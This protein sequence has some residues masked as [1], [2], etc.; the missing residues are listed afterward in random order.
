MKIAGEYV[1]AG[2]F[3]DFF[4]GLTSV[5]GTRRRCDLGDKGRSTRRR[6]QMTSANPLRVFWNHANPRLAMKPVASK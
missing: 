2:A 4:V 1:F 5:G 6:F 3:T